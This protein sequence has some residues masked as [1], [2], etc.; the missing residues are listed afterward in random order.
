MSGRSEEGELTALESALR[1]LLP[2]SG[3][4]H[5]D[6]LMYRAGRAAARSRLWPAATLVSTTMALVLGMVLWI[7]PAPPTVFVAV[8]VAQNHEES[9]SVAAPP[10]GDDTERGGWSRYLLLQEQIALHGLDGLPVP[11]SAA[12]DPP[13]DAKSLWNSL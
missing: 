9:A 8:P 1:E 10:R 13:S 2:K 7:R 4:I 3:G 5:R 11:P 12:D 6:V